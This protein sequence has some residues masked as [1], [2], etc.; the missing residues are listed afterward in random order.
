MTSREANKAL[1]DKTP[2]ESM[3]NGM[4]EVEY[5]NK[6]MSSDMARATTSAFDGM[7]D[8]LTNFVMTGKLEITDLVNS[9]IKDFAR[10]AIQQ[11]ITSPL[12]MGLS[13]AFSGVGYSGNWVNPDTGSVF[14]S[15]GG[16]S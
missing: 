4:K 5:T 1:S 7:T 10:I 6:Q 12:A 16:L 13:G 2:W 14:G 11:S 15:I 3:I 9:I 8:A